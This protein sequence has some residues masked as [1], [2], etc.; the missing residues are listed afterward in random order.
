[1]R[2]LLT[3]IAIVLSF[4]LNVEARMNVGIVGGSVAAATGESC[5]GSLVVIAHFENNDDIT[6]GTPAGCSATGDTTWDRAT[7]NGD[8]AYTADAATGSGSY[9]LSLPT[10]ASSE[11]TARLTM[12]GIDGAQL[13]LDFWMKITVLPASGTRM[14]ANIYYNNDNLADLSLST[15]GNI[16]ARHVG[17]GFSR[18][19]TTTACNLSTGTWYHIIFAYR[20]GASDPSMSVT[21]DANTE[22]ITSDLYT[23][24]GVDPGLLIVGFGGNY[25]FDGQIDYLKLYT[26]YS[27]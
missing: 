19:L 11:D 27:D 21:C 3:G 16:V 14:I 8:S 20:E 22:T 26:T 24:S 6:V 9:S 13:R 1:M 23:Q 17:G 10:D 5:T 4:A 7:G 15:S 12:A 18:T 25:A 2:K